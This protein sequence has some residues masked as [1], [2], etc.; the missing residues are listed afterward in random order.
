[1]DDRQLD[2][3]LSASAVHQVQLLNDSLPA[4][5][6]IDKVVPTD[7]FKQYMKT[8]I[9]KDEIRR[10]RLKSRKRLGKVA[11]AFA[12]VLVIT[13]GSVLSA[14]ASRSYFMHFFEKYFTVSSSANKS[15]DTAFNSQIIQNVHDCYLPTW[16]PAGL[17]AVQS[18]Q[19]NKRTTV[20]YQLQSQSLILIQYSD[21]SITVLSDNEIR[22]MKKIEIN[23]VVY[24]YSEKQRAKDVNRSLI[25]QIG[26]QSFRIESNISNDDILKVAQNLAFKKG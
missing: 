9:V 5:E 12:V 20:T 6:E 14:E 4:D 3:L 24:Y 21:D 15:W 17:Q 16:L 7:N 23:S 26:K 10:N 13:F 8:I 1:M 22:D 25:W 11:A 19:T 18:S 2:K